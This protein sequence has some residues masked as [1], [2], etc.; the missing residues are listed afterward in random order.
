SKGGNMIA[1]FILAFALVPLVLAQSP[2]GD[3]HVDAQ[4]QGNT[5]TLV[6][7]MSMD[8]TP[9]QVWDVLTDYGHMAEFLSTITASKVIAHRD[10]VLTVAQQG[11]SGVGLL[12]VAFSS[13]REVTLTPFHD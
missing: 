10:N 2:A 11:K 3:I 5:I 13:V 6:V 8:A 4:R 1:S 7:D 9:N 12:S